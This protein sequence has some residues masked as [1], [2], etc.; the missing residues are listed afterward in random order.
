MN[1]KPELPRQDTTK[2]MSW[3]SSLKAPKAKVKTSDQ[4]QDDREG[5]GYLTAPGAVLCFVH[6]VNGPGGVACAGYVPTRHEL[7]QLVR[8]WITEFLRIE[9]FF[10]FEG[11][12]GSADWRTSVYAVRRLNRIVGVLGKEAVD[13][14]VSDVK[15]EF[16]RRFGD[17]DW[18]AFENGD[19]AAQER[20]VAESYERSRQATPETH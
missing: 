11:Q 15:N 3:L 5:L 16:R 1:E 18:E 7:L 19:M 4:E 20:I 13:A 6:E 10:F 12:V 14:V 8:Y 17:S 9:T 2:F